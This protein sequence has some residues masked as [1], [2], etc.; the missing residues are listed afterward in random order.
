MPPIT[1]AQ[2]QAAFAA[3]HWKGW[4]FE[5]AMANDMRRRL[6]VAR[7]HQIRT[8]EWLAS[9]DTTTAV[10]RRVRLDAQGQVAGWCT[11]AVM[12]PRQATQ[13]PGPPDQEKNQ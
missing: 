3:M 10:V 6:V 11:Q 13:Q 7:A 2:L 12:G 9:L 1:Q 8:R 5:A 4:T